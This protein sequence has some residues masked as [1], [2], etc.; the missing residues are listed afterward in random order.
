MR[1]GRFRR[2]YIHREIEIGLEKVYS[3][4]QDTK[5]PRQFSA[6]FIYGHK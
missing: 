1:M 5:S 6:V 3:I 2:K 4:M